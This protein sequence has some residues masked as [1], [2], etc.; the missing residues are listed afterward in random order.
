[1]G[2]VNQTIYH[3]MSTIRGYERKGYEPLTPD[4]FE[5]KF[6]SHD[7]STVRATIEGK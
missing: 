1:M 7:L 3:M 6:S 2:L 5:E 4:E